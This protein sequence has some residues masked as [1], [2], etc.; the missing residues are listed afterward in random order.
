[1]RART[2]ARHLGR[3]AARRPHARREAVRRR[4]PHDR[5]E[6]DRDR[7]RRG[8]LGSGSPPGASRAAGSGS[9]SGA[10]RAAGSGSPPGSGASGRRPVVRRALPDQAARHRHGPHHGQ[11]KHPPGRADDRTARPYRNPPPER[12]APGY[13][14]SSP[15]QMIGPA[16][17]RRLFPSQHLDPADYE[18]YAAR[19][20]REF[21]KVFAC[22]RAGKPYAVKRL[23]VN[24]C[25]IVGRAEVTCGNAAHRARPPRFV[26][27]GRSL[28]VLGT[29]SE[30]GARV[31]DLLRSPLARPCRRRIHVLIRI[32]AASPGPSRRIGA[33]RTP[34]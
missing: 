9:R 27:E 18:P 10:S 11:V 30:D 31:E 6:A 24:V 12:A 16:G 2:S 22:G 17:K 25:Q 21:G 23:S 28:L 26:P 7:E 20:G 34:S 8:R 4:E 29:A 33:C 14:A 13:C 3:W 5:R 15:G 32:L 1:M 19:E